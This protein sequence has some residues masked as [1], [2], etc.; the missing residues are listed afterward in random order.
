M[1]RL[2]PLEVK[3]MKQNKIIHYNGKLFT[4]TSNEV[5]WFSLRNH[6]RSC[7]FLTGLIGLVLVLIVLIPAVVL[8]EGEV[9]M[10]TTQKYPDGTPKEIIYYQDGKEIAKELFDE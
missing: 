1:K 4:N 9:I 10:K 7:R 8:G 3:V 6:N 2:T 5:K